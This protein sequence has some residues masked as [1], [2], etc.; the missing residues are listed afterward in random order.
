[1]AHFLLCPYQYPLL[2]LSCLK[3]GDFLIAG[4]RMCSSFYYFSTFFLSTLFLRN[5]WRDLDQTWTQVRY[6]DIDVQGRVSVRMRGH[7]P[8]QDGR[9]NR[10]KLKFLGFQRKLVLRVNRVS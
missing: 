4:N 10:E 1:M 3:G 2:R 7:A 8:F 5:Y 6:G 9:Q